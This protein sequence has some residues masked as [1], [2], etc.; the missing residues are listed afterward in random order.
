[1]N[2]LAGTTRISTLLTLAAVAITG[3][4]SG[5]RP[6]RGFDHRV[7]RPVYEATRPLVFFDEAHHNGHRA[8]G[9]YRAFAKLIEAD[10]YRVVRSASRLTRDVLKPASVLVIANALGKNERNDDAAFE[11]SECEAVRAWVADGGALLLITDH[12]PT[13]HAAADLAAQFGVSFSKGYVADST[14]YDR[15]FDESHIVFSAQNGGLARH[16]IVSGRD[17]TETLRSVLTF[18]GQALHADPPAIGF[19][20]LSSDAVARSPRPVVERRGGD[21]LVRVEYADPTR[22]P[23]WS[24]GIAIEHGAG[25]VV[26]LGEAAMLSAQLYRFDGH[27]I[28][29]NVAGYD[30]RQMALNI[31]HWLTRIL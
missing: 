17:S 23:G 2:R 29:M 9:S 14:R 22:V 24:Q 19:L 3:C 12:Y 30:N 8:R 7:A 4:S 16:P 11:S 5:D 31:M 10:G 20:R 25:R 26:V 6:D 15:A 21:V 13:G 27:P 18:S 1:M 28:G